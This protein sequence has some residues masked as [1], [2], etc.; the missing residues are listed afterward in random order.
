MK[1]CII[2][3]LLGVV[4]IATGV[5]MAQ[6]ERAIVE[7]DLDCDLIYMVD[8]TVLMWPADKMLAVR[9]GDTYLSGWCRGTLPETIELPKKAVHI[10]YCVVYPGPEG[11]CDAGLYCKE[12]ITPSG[13]VTLTCH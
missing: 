11:P 3:I 4:L 9:K 8:G 6:A 13:N 5:S 1:Q 7:R 10:D 12:V 2:I